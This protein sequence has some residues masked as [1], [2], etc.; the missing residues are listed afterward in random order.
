MTAINILVDIRSVG[1]SSKKLEDF[2][3]GAVKKVEPEDNSTT[4]I[5]RYLD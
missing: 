1:K 3:R 4:A 5:C 2:F